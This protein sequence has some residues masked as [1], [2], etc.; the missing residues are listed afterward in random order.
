MPPSDF[1]TA[2]IDKLLND[3]TTAEAILLT[4]GEG[5][6]HTQSV[7]RLGIPSIKVCQCHSPISW[8]VVHD[9]AGTSRLVM[10]RMVFEEVITLW[11]RL[12][13]VCQ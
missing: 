11:V 5:L 3:L 4:A 10:A 1:A 8:S 13:I 7:E 9:R 12:Q 2:D 6:W